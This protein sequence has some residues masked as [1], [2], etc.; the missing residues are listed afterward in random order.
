M[1]GSRNGTLSRK[2]HEDH[3]TASDHQ[4]SRTCP[5]SGEFDVHH[6][7]AASALAKVSFVNSQVSMHTDLPSRKS[8]D[9]NRSQCNREDIQNIREGDSVSCSEQVSVDRTVYIIFYAC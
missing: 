9:E 6:I 2:E 8:L 3:S 7:S 1:S 4:I 5:S